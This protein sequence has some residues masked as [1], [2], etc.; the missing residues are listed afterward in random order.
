MSNASVR[1]RSQSA[2]NVE[3]WW[4]WK[5]SDLTRVQGGDGP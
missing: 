1:G 2:G 5:V 3:W 4:W